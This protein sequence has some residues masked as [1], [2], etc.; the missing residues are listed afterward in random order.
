MN[1]IACADQCTFIGTSGNYYCW[2]MGNY[3][4][5]CLL[6]TNSSLL[7]RFTRRYFIPFRGYVTPALLPIYYLGVVC[8]DRS[9]IYAHNPLNSVHLINTYFY[10]H[11]FLVVELF[12]SFFFEFIQT[13]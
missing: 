2:P 6:I 5:Y 13:I 4:I 1:I 7:T 11:I 8:F 9:V 12:H 3:Q 10:R